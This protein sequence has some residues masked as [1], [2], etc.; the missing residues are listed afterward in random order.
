MK[1]P[2]INTLSSK[3]FNLG[4]FL[5][6]DDEAFHVARTAISSR[7][8]LVYHHHNYA[9]IFWI[10]QG[11]GVHV[12]NG[13]E[14]L[15]LPGTLVMIRPED[16]HTFRLDK[17]QSSL[18]VTNIAFRAENLNYFKSRYFGDTDS[19]FW[20]NDASPFT[21][22]L[23]NQQLNELS[24]IVDRLI[25]Q[26]RDYLHLDYMMIHIFRIVTSGETPVGHIP[27]WLAYALD[28]YNTSGQFR[29]GIRGFVSLTN[30]SVDHVNRTLNKYLKQT[31]TETVNKAKLEYA[32][33]QLTLT[34]AAIKKISYDCGFENISYFHRIFK[35]YYGITPREYRKRNHTI[36]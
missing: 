29:N 19:Y 5:M 34:N 18:V 7:D 35:R 36:F 4:T 30:R 8:D 17:N 6:S 27:H 11:E 13:R 15:L 33:K 24:A 14:F 21:F 20:K 32:S 22:I 12:I 28:N 31:L 1:T 25:S 2:D 26:P 23:S 3:Y 16:N 9:E 10:K